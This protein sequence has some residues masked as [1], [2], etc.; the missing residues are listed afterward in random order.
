[1]LG[2]GRAG[3]GHQEPDSQ[4]DCK[5]FTMLTSAFHEKVP[6]G[7]F[8]AGISGTE[9]SKQQHGDKQGYADGV[10]PTPP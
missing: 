3:G 6:V 7:G 5:Q 9:A 10:H 4:A 8:P 2:D 1:M